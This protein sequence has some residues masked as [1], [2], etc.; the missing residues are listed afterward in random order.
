MPPPSTTSDSSGANYSGSK[1]SGGATV[2]KNSTT[3]NT[4]MHTNEINS[5]R[6]LNN[7]LESALRSM[8]V[9]DDDEGCCDMDE[10][11]LSAMASSSAPYQSSHDDGSKVDINNT[12]RLKGRSSGSAIG[13]SEVMGDAVSW[14]LD[15]ARR[16]SS[17]SRHKTI[18]S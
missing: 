6:E 16:L 18:S 10:T 4:T 12:C 1:S 3:T 5:V 15:T 17:V 2:S 13:H 7:L 11:Q 14:R 8:G 9:G